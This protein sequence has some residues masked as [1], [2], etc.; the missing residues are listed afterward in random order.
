MARMGDAERDHF[1]VSVQP[2]GS[3]VMRSAARRYALADLV[4]GITPDNC[5]GEL[6][7]GPREGREEW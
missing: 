7:W 6:G 3:N 4:E 2:D 5:R 1:D